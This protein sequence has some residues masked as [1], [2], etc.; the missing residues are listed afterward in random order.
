[1]P[2]SPC[3]PPSQ[4]LLL[5]KRSG[6]AITQPGISTGVPAT[7]PLVATLAIEEL[8]PGSPP[9]AASPAPT[10]V[11]HDIVALGNPLHVAASAPAPTSVEHDNAAI[12][13]PPHRTKQQPTHSISMCSA[14]LPAFAHAITLRGQCARSPAS[15]VVESGVESCFISTHYAAL[16]Q[17]SLPTP[18]HATVV[19][20]DGT[21]HHNVPNTPT[22]L[23]IS[24]APTP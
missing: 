12:N 10:S 8:E 3:Q 15:F 21:Q 22:S 11:Q 14:R 4:P 9:H 2:R 23:S 5:E 13:N 6:L 16:A 18:S 7:P 17:L 1:M 19:V 20:A 24:A